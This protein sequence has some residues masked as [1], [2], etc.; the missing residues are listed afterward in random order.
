MS[1]LHSGSLPRRRM[2]G[3][4]LAAVVAGTVGVRARPASARLILSRGMTGGGLA[5]IERE[6]G[7]ALVHLSLLASALQLPE[8]DQ[9]FLGRIRWVEAATGLTLEANEITNC[10][11]TG[12]H[13]GQREV[14]GWMSVNGGGRYPFVLTAI[15]AGDPGSAADTIALDVNGPDAQVDGEPAT[16]PSFVYAATAN[17]VAGDLSVVNADLETA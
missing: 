11:A 6:D 13:P 17:L 2:L 9:L 5:R 14:R 12:T 15:D 16:G 3:A 8:G 1:T 4:G 7:P 10:I